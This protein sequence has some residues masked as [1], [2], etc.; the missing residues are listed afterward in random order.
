[1]KEHYVTY[2]QADKLK[3]FGFDE[4]CEFYYNPC[5]ELRVSKDCLLSPKITNKRFLEAIAGGMATA[6]RLDQAAAWLR[7]CKGIDIEVVTILDP[8]RKTKRY[9]TN[10][11]YFSKGKFG[12]YYSNY[13]VACIRTLSYE[14][15]LELG[16]DKTLELLGDNTQISKQYE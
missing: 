11:C 3:K 2:E 6:P 12:V 9:K 16:I 8:F 5:R 10:L 1:M 14:K 4:P 13:K 15:A 7:D